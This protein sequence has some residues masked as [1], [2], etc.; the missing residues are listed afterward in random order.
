[1]PLPSSARFNS[2]QAKEDF[3]VV[4]YHNVIRSRHNVANLDACYRI[5]RTSTD[6]AMIYIR[7]AWVLGGDRVDIDLDEKQFGMLIHLISPE[8]FEVPIGFAL[9]KAFE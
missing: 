2:V 8:Q 6:G 9:E 1:M 4:I 5:K 3:G 7:D